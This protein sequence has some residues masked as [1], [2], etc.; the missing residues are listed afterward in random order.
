VSQRFGEPLRNPYT[1]NNVDHSL[2]V[3]SYE[4]RPEAMDSL[5]LMGESL[6]RVDR[7]IA[8]HLTVPEAPACVRAWAESRPEVVLSTKRPVG[9]SGWDVKPWL[10]LQELD[11]GRPRALWL[12]ADMIVT[13]SV[14]LMLREFPHPALI[15]AEEWNRQR[16]IPVS[17]L[18]DLPCLRLV[19]PIN[20]CFLQATAEAI[21]EMRER[22]G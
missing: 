3:C 6:C 11:A 14:S 16:A 17:H 1:V 13:R 5:I 22:A 10:L 12:D 4:D 21:Y 8:L 19:R 15:V 7:K 2:C 18:W 9:V 20:S